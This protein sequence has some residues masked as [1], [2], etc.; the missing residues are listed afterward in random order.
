MTAST[1]RMQKGDLAAAPA[2]THG[3]IS[4]K[5]VE[6]DGVSV[7]EVTFGVGAV[8]S[9]DLK[10]DVGTESCELPHVA[11]VLSGTLHVVMDDGSEEDFGPHSVMLLPPGHDAWSVGDEP[12]T[13]VEFSRGNDI[14]G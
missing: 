6:L 7:T 12:C 14:Y 9:K 3:A 13:F 2:D 1:R 4:K 5:T 8:W 11:L 10:P